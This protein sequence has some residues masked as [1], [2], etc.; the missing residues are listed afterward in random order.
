MKPKGHMHANTHEYFGMS[1][2]SCAAVVVVVQEKFGL[3]LYRKKCLE[4]YEAMNQRAFAVYACGA[5]CASNQLMAVVCV[6]AALQHVATTRC[7]HVGV[8]MVVH[9]SDS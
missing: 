3:A 5:G 2:F 4:Q 6:R 7:V 8:C 1:T 9:V